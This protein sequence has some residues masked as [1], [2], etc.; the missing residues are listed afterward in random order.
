MSRGRQDRCDARH[1]ASR[2]S[3]SQGRDALIETIDGL[4]LY[5]SPAPIAAVGFAPEFARSARNA[6]VRPITDIGNV[7]LRAIWFEG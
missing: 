5:D 2:V 3:V 4:R 6:R 7:C 1:R